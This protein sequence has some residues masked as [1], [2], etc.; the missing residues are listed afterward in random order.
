VTD[1]NGES[2][3]ATTAV[4][5]TPRV[6]LGVTLAV[7]TGSANNSKV[8]VTVT[9]TVTP[10]TGGA[11]IAQSFSWDFGDGTT[12]TTSGNSTTHVYTQGV[13]PVTISVTVSTTD[14]RS[15]TGQTQANP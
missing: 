12:A 2:G 8:P 10:A 14:G 3:S 7:S 5:I 15:V 6:P 4:G 9:A 13:G 1:V 11:D